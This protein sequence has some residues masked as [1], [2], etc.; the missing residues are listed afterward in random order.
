MKGIVHIKN[1][2]KYT[3]NGW[4]RVNVKGSPSEMGFAHGQL[5]S[6][7]IAECLRNAAFVCMNS[8][9]YKFDKLAAVFF[10]VFS[11]RIKDGYPE[12]M[13]EIEGVAKGSK[14]DIKSVFLWNCWYSI[15]YVIG[16]MHEIVK[17]DP[18]LNSKYGDMFPESGSGGGAEGGAADRCTAFIA[19]GDWTEDGKI[20]CAHNTFD[21]FIDSQFC[22]IML[23]VK[24]KKGNSFIM[25]CAPGQIAS[26]TDYYITSNGFIVTE[27]TIGG[28]S[29]YRM[30]DPIFAR[31]RTAVQT[32]K[33]IDDYIEKLKHNNS[34]DYANSW[35]I[36]DTNTNEICRIE[37]GLD[38]VNVER[39]KNGYFIGFNAPYDGRI[40]NLECKNTGF[41][42]IRRH[43]GSRRVRLEQ[44]MKQH[45]GKITVP[46]GQEILA[47]HYDVY[48]NKINMCSRTCC[49]HYELDQREFMSQSDRPFPYQPRGAVDGIVTSSTLAKQMGMSGRWGT[50]CGTP[51]IV[52]EFIKRNPQW[53]DQAPYLIDRPSQPWTIFTCKK[54]GKAK[55]TR[56]RKK[57]KRGTRRRK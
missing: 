27:T 37:L 19:V 46:I 10:D 28:F 29:V 42:D 11:P 50:S 34:G 52:S 4:I 36:G 31:I 14:A 18:Q 1:G 54:K 3:E 22:N 48:L 15:G 35:L 39:K 47:D 5:L 16:S 43:Q 8:Y 53:E 20:V 2:T 17:S 44:L 41:Y 51:F 21:N 33:S 12:L 25:Q 30:G 55:K 57:G 23:C 45:K 38:Y 9:G 49:S 6:K 7:E 40:R 32:S 24:P 13:E 26:G 56:E